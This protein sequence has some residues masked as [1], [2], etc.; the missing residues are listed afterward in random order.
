MTHSAG[1]LIVCVVTFSS[2]C[3]NRLVKPHCIMQR[4]FH[5]C[6]KV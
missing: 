5:P 6:G 4:S 1:P 2:C 3:L